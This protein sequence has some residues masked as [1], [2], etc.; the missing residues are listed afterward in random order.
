MSW[1]EH[2]LHCDCH[3]CSTPDPTYAGTRGA[4]RGLIERLSRRGVSFKLAGYKVRFYPAGAI[5]GDIDELRRL[6]PDV[7][8]LLA[9][10][11]ARKHKGE[12]R[13]RDE[14]EAFELAREHFGLEEGA[15]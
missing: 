9:E 12:G 10:D 6:K 2:P 5:G 13:V 1:R 8:R 15:A 11:D 3:E 4:A 14:L 7:V